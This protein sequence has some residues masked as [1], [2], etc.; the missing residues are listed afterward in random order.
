MGTEYK[1]VNHTNGTFYDL[2]KGP[3]MDILEFCESAELLELFFNEEW[4]SFEGDQKESYF[5]ALANDIFSFLSISDSRFCIISDVY[6]DW[7]YIRALNYTCVGSR[8]GLLNSYSN[9]MYIRDENV[10]LPIDFPLSA[11]EKQ[12]LINEGYFFGKYKQ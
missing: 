8:F 2:G 6:H 5:K 7:I 3:F 4:D 11:Q 1:L 12:N 10:G 9:A